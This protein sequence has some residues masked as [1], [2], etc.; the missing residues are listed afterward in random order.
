MLGLVGSPRQ[1]QS[2]AISKRGRGYVDYAWF[3]QLTTDAV[4]FV[5]RLKDNVERRAVPERSP[6]AGT[7]SSA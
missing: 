1:T 5:I 6:S 7:R 4:F 3:G 2:V